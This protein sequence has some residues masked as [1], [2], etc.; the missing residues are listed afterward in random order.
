LIEGACM[1]RDPKQVRTMRAIQVAQW[2]E[3]DQLKLVELP[4]PSP[5]PT[6]IRVRVMAA[7][8]NPVDVFTRQGRAYMNA[9]TLP[10][11]P[12]WDAAGVVDAIGYGVTRFKVGDWVFGMPWFPRAGSTYA[13]YV[14]APASHF[15]AMPPDLDFVRA[16]ALPLAGL[17]AWQML[18]NVGRVAAGMRVL[19]N[20]AA[21]GVGH[22]AVQIAK[23]RGAFVIATARQE[24]HAFL[25][26]LGADLVI[27]YTEVRVP[28]LIS[29]ADL[30]LELVGGETC[31][32]MLPTLRKGGLLVSAQAAWAPTLM[33]EAQSLGVRASWYLVEPDAAGL[34]ELARLV[35]SDQLHVHVERV[36][37]LE[38]AAAAQTLVAGKRVSGKVVLTIPAPGET[39]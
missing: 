33:D 14:V 29:D 28:D 6:E 4:R 2:G 21:G 25:R 35:E 3:E 17:T 24:K 23:A 37:A 22:L 36:L 9:L 12:G 20:G 8:V 38:E 26:S 31:L 15:C 16:A 7:G 18:V 10:H 32:A 13:E 11:I 34:A 1:S 5:L 39:R 30:V 19:I 27:D